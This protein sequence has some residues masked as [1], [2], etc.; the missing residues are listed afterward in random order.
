MSSINF[1]EPKTSRPD[2]AAETTE[3]RR[4]REGLGADRNLKLHVPEESKDPNY[5]YRWVNDRPGRVRQL[6]TMDDYDVVSANELG[7]GDPEPEK[8]ASEGTT[9]TRIGDARAG[10]KVV[11]MKKL[12]THFE[13]DRKEHDDAIAARED[14]MRKGKP[15]TPDANNGDHAYTP[16]G[17]NVVNGR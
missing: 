12:K 11:L 14:T 13:A 17:K 3:R 15:L 2:R 9:M 4:R 16:G 1:V 8:N 5:I 10:E 7:G 6:S